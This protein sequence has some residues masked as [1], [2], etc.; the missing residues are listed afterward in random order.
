MEDNGITMEAWGACLLSQPWLICYCKSHFGTRKV[1]G[2]ISLTVC[3]PTHTHTHIRPGFTV[4]L[5]RKFIVRSSYT[6]IHL[7]YVL[8]IFHPMYSRVHIIMCI[9]L[10]FCIFSLLCIHLI[11]FVCDFLLFPKWPDNTFYLFFLG[12]RFIDLITRV[13]S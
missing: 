3:E 1:S 4:P 5:Q 6:A 12:Y 13:L 7:H 8:D 10:L 9:V 2:H 11:Q